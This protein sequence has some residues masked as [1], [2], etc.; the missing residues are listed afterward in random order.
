M[1]L[2]FSSGLPLF[3]TSST[4]AIW[5]TSEGVT[6][7]NVGLLG[8]VAL[9]YAFK[10]LWAPLID[11]LPLPFFTTR[12]GR[13]R[14]WMIFSQLL[15][16][17]SIIMFAQFNPAENLTRTAY[18][19]LMI[20]FCAAT[21]ETLVLTYQM[22]SLNRDQYGPGE[23][24]GILGYRLGMMTSGAVALYLADAVNWN[25]AYILMGL[26]ICIGLITTLVIDEPQ[27]IVKPEELLIEQKAHDY[28]HAHP[29]LN[30]FSA[31]LLSWI[32]GAVICPFINII[33]R[34]PTWLSL[35]LLMI[36]YKVGDNLIG[37]MGNVFFVE[38]GFSFS[39]IASATKVFGLFATILGGLIG[40]V[41]V[42]KYGFLRCMLYFTVIHGATHLLYVVLTHNS[43]NMPLLYLTVGLQHLTSGMNTTALLAYQLTL[44]SQH[45]AATQLALLASLFFTGRTLFAPL[46]GYL[47][48]QL[49]WPDFFYVSF[50]VT[51]IPII[52][53]LHLIKRQ[54]DPIPQT[55]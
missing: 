54:R 23:A 13:R 4:L 15:L 10:F 42:T 53:V 26:G 46:S 48:D 34:N 8:L 47:A 36:L 37:T 17:A 25:V 43:G 39:E 11:R 28:L 7:T 12:F 3:L 19:A 6:K 24:F 32:Y 14:G 41:L 1:L 29:S 49:S 27:K 50:A 38:L 51:A 16:I 44:C 18:L 21:Q 9:P 2:G 45:Y 22:E 33:Q 40:G 5:L 52:I 55:V 30:P 35:I 31:K 20:S